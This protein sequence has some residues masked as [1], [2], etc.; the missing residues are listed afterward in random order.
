MNRVNEKGQME[1]Y[2][3]YV[4]LQLEWCTYVKQNDYQ[5]INININIYYSN[6][7]LL[8]KVF[9]NSSLVIQW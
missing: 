1:M 6:A 9:W 2:E 5:N 8:W 7:R 3:F 4:D